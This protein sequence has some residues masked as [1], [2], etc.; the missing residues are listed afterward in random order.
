MSSIAMDLRRRIT[1]DFGPTATLARPIANSDAFSYSSPDSLMVEGSANDAEMTIDFVVVTDAVDR[2]GDIIIPSGCLEYID[3]FK[4]NSAFLLEHNALEQIGTCRNKSGDF[5]FRVEDHRIVAT[6]H[7]NRLPLR[8]ERLSEEIYRLTKAGVFIGA[9]PGFLPIRAKKRG[10]GK[11]D[12]YQYDAWRL[13]EISQTS[14]P[15]QQESLRLSLSRGIVKSMGLKTRLESLLIKPNP[16]V[17][18][19]FSPKIADEVGTSEQRSM[20]PKTAAIEFQKSIF[21]TETAC[22]AWL[23]AHGYDSSSCIPLPESFVFTQRSG[24]PNAGMKSLGTGVVG[25][26]TKAFGKDEK[27]DDEDEDK[28][29]KPADEKADMEDDKIEKSDDEEP[30]DDES[31]DVEDGDAEDAD[32]DN[33]GEETPAEETAEDEAPR[34]PAEMKAESDKILDMIAHTEIA[35]EHLKASPELFAEVME[36]FEDAA[37]KLRD[38]HKSGY[39]DQ[40]VNDAIEERKAGAV[41]KDDEPVDTSEANDPEVMKALKSLNREATKAAKTAKSLPKIYQASA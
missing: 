8:G 14:Q 24:K 2:E 13:T 39:A 15:V 31:D 5:K 40:M 22:A 32:A 35:I 1:K 4:A 12:G 20:K 33:E 9:S 37:G 16:V 23:D 7:Y 28:K 34:D 38:M 30:A 36:A 3:E 21:K 25:L 10:Y 18:G 29:K 19:G 27:D 11:A 41:A 6:N 26:M 17:R